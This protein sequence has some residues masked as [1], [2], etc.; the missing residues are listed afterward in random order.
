MS[1]IIAFPYSLFGRSMLLAQS[2]SL[3]IGI[4][5][6]CLTFKISQTLFGERTAKNAAWLVTLYPSIIL[7]SVLVL[8]EI[9]FCFFLLIALYGVL[10]WVRYKNISSIILGLLG[11]IATNSFTEL[12]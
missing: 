5:C 7:Y 4:C 10:N 11:F 6:I 1:L 3:L 12:E 8:R 2:L 9:Y